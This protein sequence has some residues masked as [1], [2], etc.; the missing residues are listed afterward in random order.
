M[1][2]KCIDSKVSQNMLEMGKQVTC[3]R[4]EGKKVKLERNILH[5]LHDS[6]GFSLVLAVERHF[7]FPLFLPEMQIS[8]L[9]F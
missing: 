9:E 7:L 6:I 5:P 8:R 1:S 4:K 3:V 2:S